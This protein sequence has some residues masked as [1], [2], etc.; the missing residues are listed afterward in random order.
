MGNRE[1]CF[2][3]VG[4]RGQNYDFRPT[5][6]PLDEWNNNIRESRAGTLHETFVTEKPPS[7]AAVPAHYW[8]DALRHSVYLTLVKDKIK[9]LMTKVDIDTSDSRTGNYDPKETEDQGLWDKIKNAPFKRLP[10]E[11]PAVGDV[12]IMAKGRLLE[13]KKGFSFAEDEKSKETCNDDKCNQ[14]VRAFWSVKRVRQRDHETSPGKYHYELTF[15]VSSQTPK[16]PKKVQE[17]PIITYTV[18]ENYPRRIVDK[19]Q[20]YRKFDTPKTQTRRPERAIWFHRNIAPDKQ[21]GRRQFFQGFDS[22]FSSLFSND[23]SNP[24]NPQPTKH[25]HNPYGA[26]VG[27][28][29]PKIN[30]G[31]VHNDHHQIPYPYK[32]NFN[33]PIQAPPILPPLNSIQQYQDLSTFTTANSNLYPLYPFDQRMEPR[34][35]QGSKTNRPAVLPTP[36]PPISPI[37]DYSIEATQP[38]SFEN[39]DNTTHP[40]DTLNYPITHNKHKPYKV[41]YFSDHI[42]PPVYNAPP[43]VFVTMDKKPFKPMPPLKYAHISKPHRPNRPTDFRPSPQVMDVQFSDPDSFGDTAFRPITVGYAENNKTNNI[44]LT[45]KKKDNKSRK[46]S[47]HGKKPLKKHETP[48]SQHVS[49]TV[50]DIITAQTLTSSEIETLDWANI[51][52]AFTKTTPMVSQTEGVRVAE[53]TTTPMSTTV[54][55][56]K[57]VTS[58]TEKVASISTTTKTPLKKRTRPPP[59]FKK[60]EKIKKHKRTTTTTTTTTTNAPEDIKKRPTHDLTPQASSAATAI[61]TGTTKTYKELQNH[62]QQPTTLSSTTTTSTTTKPTTTTAST[63]TTVTT[64]KLTSK[65]PRNK[66][67]F[68]QS[69]LILKGTSVKH[70]RWNASQR[71][72]STATLTSTTSSHRRK[73]SNFQGYMSSTA[74]PID[75]AREKAHADKTSTTTTTESSSTKAS[76]T[77]SQMTPSIEETVDQYETNSVVPFQASNEEDNSFDESNNSKLDT[78]L[79]E[80]NEDI[81]TTPSSIKIT[82]DGNAKNKTKCKKKKNNIVTTEKTDESESITQVITSQPLIGRTGTVASASNIEEIINFNF[83]DDAQQNEGSKTDQDYNYENYTKTGDDF[84]DIFS[85]LDG[86]QNQSDHDD[87]DEDDDDDNQDDDGDTEFDDDVETDHKAPFSFLE[88]MAMS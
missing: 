12:T 35:V 34:P 60:E 78:S 55:T 56:T 65:E 70:D 1:G 28:Q 7:I 53:T 5:P 37:R 42:R 13:D 32:P 72:Q 61:P 49:T 84:E 15:S 58:T 6:I 62:T 48:K 11:E 31:G 30:H 16:K 38:I 20:E 68:R 23:N 17:N 73:G 87:Y 43:G 3:Q 81:K 63:E 2:T 41:N 9:Q 86:K 69:T 46:H 83:D 82:S 10:E 26:P 45:N 14:G 54:T 75:E 74:R 19:P 77:T 33:L 57:K 85:L 44:E 4:I 18:R 52:G 8:E 51:L 59:K 64:K 88:L 21:I 27:Y 24:Y 76:E 36:L 80:D 40:S 50:P 47:S 71:N 67:R 79:T 29:N 25:K 22:L 66:N 39:F